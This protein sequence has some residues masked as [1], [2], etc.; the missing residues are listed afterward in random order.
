MAKVL[1]IEFKGGRKA[2]FANP[3]EFPFIVGD[4]AVVQADKGEDLGM[5]VNMKR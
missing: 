3:L 2:F 1:E 5:I 4:Q